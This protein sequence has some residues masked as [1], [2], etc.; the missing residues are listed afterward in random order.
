[1]SYLIDITLDDA[2]LPKPTPEVEQERRVAIHDILEENKFALS[3]DDAPDGPFK[4]K[5][6][7]EEKRLAFNVT[8]QDD[9]L[10]QNY[11]FS[12]T[13]LSQVIKDYFEIVESYFKAVTSLPPAQIEAIDMGRRGIRNEGAEQLKDRLS[14]KIEIDQDT[15]RRLFTLICALH[16]KG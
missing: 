11:L 7:L 13:P 5:M 12:I 4:L 6:G 2:A 10:I 14:G 15:S 1:M 9:N 3:H 16:F 8:D